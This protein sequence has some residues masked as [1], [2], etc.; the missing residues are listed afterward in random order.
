MYIL[1][2]KFWLQI[3]NFLTLKQFYEKIF[4]I[5]IYTITGKNSEL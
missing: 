4:S 1:K 3:V 5:D 2:Y